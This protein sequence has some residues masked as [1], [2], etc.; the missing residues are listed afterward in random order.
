MRITVVIVAN[1]RVQS[2][3]YSANQFN[4]QTGTIIGK[5]GTDKNNFQVLNRQNTQVWSTPVD[6]TAWQNFAITLDFVKK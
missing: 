1:N 2:A 3:D 4:F 6:P 5:S